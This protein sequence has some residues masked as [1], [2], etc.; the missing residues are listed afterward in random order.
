M[1][2]SELFDSEDE[3]LGGT[4]EDVTLSLSSVEGGT[5]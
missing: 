4:T 3:G 1:T 5:G 2:L